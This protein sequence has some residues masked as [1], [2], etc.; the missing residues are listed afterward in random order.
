MSRWGHRPVRAKHHRVPSLIPE[1][2]AVVNF[3]EETI[4][5]REENTIGRQSLKEESQKTTLKEES[6]NIHNQDKH[7]CSNE[8]RGE[9]K[10]SEK[11]ESSGRKDG[12]GKKDSEK[13]STDG[14]K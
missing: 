2:F 10:D 4:L 9:E 6:H 5:S 3:E 13:D 14:E 12:D 8:L 1:D 11:G 7:Q